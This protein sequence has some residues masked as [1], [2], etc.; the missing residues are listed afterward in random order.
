MFYRTSIYWIK[1]GSIGQNLYVTERARFIDLIILVKIQ[2][3]QDNVELII[4]QVHIFIYVEYSSITWEAIQTILRFWM[5]FGRPKIYR[6]LNWR[7]WTKSDLKVRYVLPKSFLN[8]LY[9][10]EY[11][12]KYSSIVSYCVVS[13]HINYKV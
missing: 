8:L 12:W 11:N 1:I 4:K 10:K 6:T 13:P 7:A 2:K 5:Y 3:E 9:K